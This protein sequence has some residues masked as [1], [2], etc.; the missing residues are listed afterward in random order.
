MSGW[1]VELPPF[2]EWGS[3]DN[4]AA[5]VQHGLG[6]AQSPV[7]IAMTTALWD[8]AGVLDRIELDGVNAIEG[9][10][11]PVNR[12][13][14][15]ARER[16]QLQF[17]KSRMC[18]F[19]VRGECTKGEQCMFA[20]GLSEI[21]CAPDL[22]KTSLCPDWQSGRCPLTAEECLRAHGP[23]DLRGTPAYLRTSLCKQFLKGKCHAGAACRHAHSEGELEAA[24]VMQER[25]RMGTAAGGFDKSWQEDEEEEDGAREVP[26]KKGLGPRA[27]GTLAA[28]VGMF[29]PPC[30][31]AGDEE[32]P[33][34]RPMVFT[35]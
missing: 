5:T 7:K 10:R 13:A 34:E 9:S 1:T 29:P 15:V 28:V 4:S 14:P 17:R 33:M 19:F 35:F 27:G 8:Q 18:R 31:Y 30:T 32:R 2:R 24:Q 22:R 6:A 20:H 3:Q 25:L 23:E 11:K 12:R 26:L 16:F 21:R